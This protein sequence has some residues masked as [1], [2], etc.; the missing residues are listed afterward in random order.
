MII[1]V[2]PKVPILQLTHVDMLNGVYTVICLNCNDTFY[3][4][5]DMDE[6]IKCNKC[7]VEDNLSHLLAYRVK[8]GT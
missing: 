7:G 4:M 1:D 6:D 8:S 3:W 2:L 5:M